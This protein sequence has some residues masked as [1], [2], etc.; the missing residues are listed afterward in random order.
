MNTIDKEEKGKLLTEMTNRGNH[1]HNMDVIRAGAGELH[2]ARSPDSPEADWKLYYPC[3]L[4]LRWYNSEQ[5]YRH[6]CPKAVDEKKPSIKKSKLLLSTATG[7]ITAGMAS[8]L[9]SLVKNDVGIIIEQDELLMNWLNVETD[10]G[11][12]RAKKVRDLLRSKLRYAGRLLAEVRKQLPNITMFEALRVQNFKLLVSA[13]R[14]CAVDRDGEES[15]ETRIKIGQV[16]SACLKRRRIM[17]LQ[18]SDKA[19]KNKEVEETDDLISLFDEDWPK[20]ISKPSRIEMSKKRENKLITIPTTAD[21]VKFAGG[22]KERLETAI[23]EFNDNTSHRYNF[24]RLQNVTLVRVIQLNRR[25][26]LVSSNVECCITN[27]SLRSPSKMF[28]LLQKNSYFLLKSLNE[29]S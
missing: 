1:L 14:S 28:C 8:I 5:L 21:I 2:V 7:A 19:L 11:S 20:L 22:L 10:G 15:W 4:C 26:G 27:I 16:L 9:S 13:T 29:F 3:H 12:W 18:L 6:M 17:G 25:R 23:K 24:R